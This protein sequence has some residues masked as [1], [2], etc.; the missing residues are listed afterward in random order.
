MRSVD[1]RSVRL[2][3]RRRL[4]S[5]LLLRLWWSWSAVVCLRLCVIVI[6]SPRL[7]SRRLL[8]I[9][10]LRSWLRPL[11]GGFGRQWG[12]IGCFR[13]FFARFKPPWGGLGLPDDLGYVRYRC[14]PGLAAR[15][16]CDRVF[17]AHA[18]EN[19]WSQRF[20]GA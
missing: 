3:V 8:T 16:C 10:R 19:L 12:E 20:A 18:L 5:W 17:C 13:P 14:L 2:L 11:S 1:G 4:R 9:V 6:P 7:L 15:P